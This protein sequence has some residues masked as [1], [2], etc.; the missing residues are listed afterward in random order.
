MKFKLTTNGWRCNSPSIN[1]CTTPM[2]MNNCS[3]CDARYLEFPPKLLRKY[4]CYKLHLEQSALNKL[5][6]CQQGGS[7]VAGNRRYSSRRQTLDHPVAA[8]GVQIGRKITDKVECR[9]PAPENVGFALRPLREA[10]GCHAAHGT[11]ITRRVNAV[12]SQRK[13]S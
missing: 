5:R 7:S 2:Y 11:Q 6:G 10:G 12:C 1:L 9:L 8:A 13:C 3:S 4:C